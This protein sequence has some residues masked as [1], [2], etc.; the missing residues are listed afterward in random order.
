MVRAAYING[1]VR[2]CTMVH[3]G[4]VAGSPYGGS[5]EETK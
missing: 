2:R 3:L 4:D 5:I 1:Q